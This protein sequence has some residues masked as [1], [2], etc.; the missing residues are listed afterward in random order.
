MAGSVFCA[1]R[2]IYENNYYINKQS[3]SY[4]FETVQ[5]VWKILRNPSKPPAPF[6]IVRIFKINQN[7]TLE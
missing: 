6:H 4:V 2:K 5:V 7:Y 1:N 3:S